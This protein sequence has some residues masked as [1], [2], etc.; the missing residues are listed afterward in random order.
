MDSKTWAQL[1]RLA[2]YINCKIAGSVIVGLPSVHKAS[3]YTKPS[4]H[5]TL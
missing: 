1:C 2:L 5:K 3:V 4:V